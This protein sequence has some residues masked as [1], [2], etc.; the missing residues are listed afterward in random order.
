M[1]LPQ[2]CRQALSKSAM[3]GPNVLWQRLDVTCIF[4]AGAM[5]PAA[6]LQVK[7]LM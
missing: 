7:R 4:L 1:G 5:H 6:P 2:G 3:V